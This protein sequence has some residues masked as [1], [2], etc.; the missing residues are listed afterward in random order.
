MFARIIIL[1]LLFGLGSARGQAPIRLDLEDAIAQALAQ[2][3]TLARNALGVRSSAY[4]IEG[5][6]A[7]F[8]LKLQPD[9]RA[10]TDQ[11]GSTLQYGLNATRSF[12][13]GTELSMGAQQAE[14]REDTGSDWD[15]TTLKV[16]LSQPLFRNA[17]IL[18]NR[19]PITQAEQQLRTARR[20][21][22]RQRGELVVDVV[23]A[24]ENLIR[25]GK[26]IESEEAAW[27]RIDK[28]YRL[29]QARE[30][31]GR[32]T[33]VD[34]L[35]VELKRG[36]SQSRLEISRDR[37]F[38][39]QR[40]F[41]ELLGAPPDQVF[42]LEPPPLLELEP[43]AAEEAVSLALSNRL[44]YAQT[45]QDY[46]DQ[47]RG[48]KIAQNAMLPSL[49]LVTRYERVDEDRNEGGL[50][51]DIWS[52]GLGGDTELTRAG[53]RARLAQ[54]TLS[55][56][57]AGETIHIREL[58]IAR[59][60]QQLLSAYQRAR[61]ELVIAERNYQLADSRARLARRLF[62]IGRGD[63]FSVTDAEDSLNDADTRRHATRAEASISGYQLMQ[64]LGILIE[65]PDDLKPGA[66]PK[67]I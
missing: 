37:L 7:E 17:G 35:R 62:E 47:L 51:E 58:S 67:K 52:V 36:Q 15:R 33:R 45:L 46:Q 20:D 54:A 26:Q 42:E 3:R 16:S 56:E 63:N 65:V 1:L 10:A 28:L 11:D 18:V 44:D 19:E 55:R 38:F 31:Q 13:P 30:R 53:E 27:K 12:L 60:V 29:T 61:S 5:A 14:R 8:R 49:S 32:A 4:G 23:A 66:I 6:Q 40:D 9:G 64:G 41:A 39:N 21:L 25:L 50:E 48:V 59:E 24:F 2:N 57:A 34:T 22:E 43:P